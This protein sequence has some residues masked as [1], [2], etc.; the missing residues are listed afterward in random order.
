MIVLLL[1]LFV[2]SVVL[3][4]SDPSVRSF[5]FAEFNSS[6]WNELQTIGLPVNADT[7]A[8]L[9]LTDAVAGQ[10]A[11][12]WY[13][14]VVLVRGFR[15]EF[16][17]NM[18]S[19]NAEHHDGV[20]FV[21]QSESGSAQGVAGA[22]LGYGD[23]NT[24]VRK[25]IVNSLAIE[26]DTFQDND[27]SGAHALH[28]PN[29][30]HVSVQT[31]GIAQAN[32]ADHSY[33]LQQNTAIPPLSGAAH[34]VRVEYLP[35]QHLQVF[36]EPLTG[37]VINITATSPIEDSLALD[38]FGAAFV[39]FTASTSSASGE[40][41]AIGNW[42]FEFLGRPIPSR[43]S[44]DG[45]GTSSAVAGDVAQFGVQLVDQF[46]NNFTDNTGVT[47][48]ATLSVS[49][50]IAAVTYVGLGRYE[51]SFNATL[52]GVATVN[53]TQDGVA[54]A[55]SPFQPTV[56]AAAVDASHCLVSMNASTLVA[57]DSL[58][59]FVRARD[60]FDNNLLV[61]GASVTCDTIFND[62]AVQE[63]H[64]AADDNDGTYKAVFVVTK[65]GPWQLLVAVDGSMVT[66]VPTLYN[67]TAA[68]VDADSCKA[69]V[70]TQLAS[71]RNNT[72]SV[73]LYDQFDNAVHV[74]D[75]VL[76]ITFDTSDVGG[77]NASSCASYQTGQ[78]DTVT[79]L[80]NCAT[81]GEYTMTIR[82]APA[83]S[84]TNWHRID[85]PFVL[86]VFP[87]DAVNASASVLFGA[88]LDAPQPAQLGA[89]FNLTTFDFNGNRR[90]APVANFSVDCAPWACAAEYVDFGVYTLSVNLTI[91]EA[92]DWNVT[93][94]GEP[95]VGSPFAV[96][97]VPAIA[98][99]NT[100]ALVN[101]SALDTAQSDEPVSVE[102][103][104][105][106]RFGN[107]VV[108][109]SWPPLATWCEAHDATRLPVGFVRRANGTALLTFTAEQSGEYS[110]YITLDG[111]QVQ[112][113]PFRVTVAW[114]GLSNELVLAIGGGLLL[115]VILIGVTVLYVRSRGRRKLY[116]S[117]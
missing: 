31:R 56:V 66:S 3:A 19:I 106:D 57:G 38:Q 7:G 91:A 11:V 101:S 97:V 48:L 40:R 27:T 64:A 39:G 8:E 43:C 86:H 15:C 2:E 77:G 44:H 69:D 104:L 65:A 17:I 53:V 85:E 83:S 14:K 16:T 116:D 23:E 68:T 92:V 50:N 75:A 117:I 4:A 114:A 94:M 67:V 81:A 107:D 36:I 1:L 46:G 33:S 112:G 61:G 99:A 60:R 90:L 45:A 22:G 30:N 28:D 88:L 76:Q 34:R 41:H 59:V 96:Q 9:V 73:Q 58:L 26:F 63:T 52:S 25:G 102:L 109:T 95:I 71:D 113:S 12:A 74:S 21:I 5:H 42:S 49:P 108:G 80:Y 24:V 72:A 100:S 35:A 103:Q 10:N 89:Q 32:S 55:G 37:P 82:V 13:R 47:L 54:I 18:S 115:L 110:L 105:R 70:D 78:D 6:N 84:P 111:A 51:V 20:A 87:A 62:T 79:V 29:A 98:V 93:L